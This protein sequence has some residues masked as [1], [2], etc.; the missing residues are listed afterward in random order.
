VDQYWVFIRNYFQVY[1]Y[2]KLSDVNFFSRFP[3]WSE[4]VF[5]DPIAYPG[6]RIRL[7]LG[8]TS[9]R[10]VVSRLLKLT[11]TGFSFQVIQCVW[12][13]WS[14]AVINKMD[15]FRSPCDFYV[16]AHRAKL[17]WKLMRLMEYCSKRAH[18]CENPSMCCGREFLRFIFERSKLD[19]LVPVMYSLKSEP[20]EDAESATWYAHQDGENKNRSPG[21]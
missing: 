8:G 5:R 15:G 12:L 6:V 16:F 1:E 18:L 9:L 2:I 13:I 3:I 17:P 11:T 4:S 10:C 14:V 19:S 21:Y 7:V 20:K